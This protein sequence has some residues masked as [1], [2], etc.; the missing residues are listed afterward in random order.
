M[1]FVDSGKY[2]PIPFTVFLWL[3]LLG[4]IKIRLESEGLMLIDV[5]MNAEIANVAEAHMDSG[6]MYVWDLEKVKQMVDAGK[7]KL[8]IVDMS[9]AGLLASLR[10]DLIKVDWKEI[11]SLT[12]EDIAKPIVLVQLENMDQPIC[13]DGWS[14]IVFLDK[15]GAK[16]ALGFML[17]QAAEKYC[18]IRGGGIDRGNYQE[19]SNA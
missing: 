8:G 11:Q 6:E 1:E 3:V 9:K 13:L 16:K 19:A 7:G 5:L 4:K 17:S 2:V 12:D 14:T 10:E 18:R 15:I